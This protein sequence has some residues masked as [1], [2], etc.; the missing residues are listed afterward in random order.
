M[1]KMLKASGGV[2]LATLLSR[3]LG[4]AREVAYANFMGNGLVASAF[5]FAY[6]LPN[7]FRRLLGEGAL[8]AAFVPHFKQKEKQEGTQEM[9]AAGNAVVSG[10]LLTT[11]LITILMMVVATLLLKSGWLKSDTALMLDL[12]RMMAPYLVLVCFA[13]VCMG[14]LNSRGYFFAPALGSCLLNLVLIASVFFIAPRM[15]QDLTQQVFGLAIG[16]VV[17]GTAQALY[18]LPWLWRDGYRMKWVNPLTDPSVKQVA[19]QMA[20]GVL[21]V[22]AFQINIMVSNAVGFW[23]ADHIVSS[24]NYA[25]R[26]M[27]LPQGLFG[28]SMAVYLLPTLSGLAADKDYKS[29]RSTL[30]EGWGYVL[31]TNFLATAMLLVLATPMVRL[32][33]ERG[34]FDELATQ[35][36][37]RALLFLAPSLVAYSTVN[38][39][40]R[41]FYALG[42]TQTPTRI[43]IGCLVLNL[44]L[45]LIFVWPL[46]EAG[47]GLANSLSSFFNVA[48]L[49]LALKKKMGQ[50]DYGP[51]RAAAW[52]LGLAAVIGGAAMGWIARSLIL[53][54]GTDSLVLKM[55]HVGVPVLVGT[56]VYSLVCWLMQAGPAMGLA[57]QILSNFRRK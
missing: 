55:M 14:M 15:G 47:M 2:A 24:F 41:A 10:I 4:M 31:A 37:A 21:G 7:L 56:L 6:T 46:Q 23:A 57:R 11:G 12:T 25:V 42:D 13:A 19:R 27:E 32:L 45:T 38:I 1:S 16:V 39:L 53:Q 9:W 40:A 51:I 50:F 33:F 49:M 35:R 30:T 26:L 3:I 8:T 52:R 48:M 5:M 29:F 28:V 22:A 34:S 20:P 54:T 43:S 18:Q 44:F 36:V 17:A